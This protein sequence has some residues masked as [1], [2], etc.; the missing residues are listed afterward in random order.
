LEL[1]PERAPAL[2]QLAALTAEQGDSA[3]AV[4]LYD[5]AATADPEDA[6]YAWGAIELLSGSDDGAELE[7]R[8]EALLARHA[9]HAAAAELLARRLSERD[10]DR[11]LALALRAVRLLG[12][13]DALDTL[14]RIQLEQGDSE[15][16]A[17]SFGASVRLRPESPSSQYWLGRALI[18]TEDEEGARRAFEASLALGAFPEREVAQ[19]EL[20]RLNGD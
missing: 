19:A 7:R 18:A 11:A 5:R 2:A 9:T 10:P 15:S 1:E 17:R 3:A 6:S 20:A 13:P 4:A 16:A 14:G 12:G 8:L